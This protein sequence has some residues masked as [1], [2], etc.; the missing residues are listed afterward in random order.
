MVSERQAKEGTRR[1][2]QAG[3]TGQD[4]TSERSLDS[5]KNLPEGK[6]L[7]EKAGLGECSFHM[8]QLRHHD[9]ADHTEKWKVGTQA[10]A[11]C[12]QALPLSGRLL[13]V[14]QGSKVMFCEVLDARGILRSPDAA[15]KAAAG[16]QRGRLD[17]DTKWRQKTGR[18]RVTGGGRCSHK[19]YGMALLSHPGQKG[20]LWTRGVAITLCVTL[21]LIS[22]MFLFVKQ[23]SPSTQTCLVT[24]I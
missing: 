4:R 15:Y 24:Q 10:K 22:F 2:Q 18:K 20:C 21:V 23:F 12:S 7:E 1:A 14:W 6:T 5:W 16:Q 8:V 9:G 19:P 3:N 13:T 11:F 17:S